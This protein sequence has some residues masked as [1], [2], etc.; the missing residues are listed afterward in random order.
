VTKR[1]EGQIVNNLN[2][3]YKNNNI[4]IQKLNNERERSF[5]C[6]NISCNNSVSNKN[7]KYNKMNRKN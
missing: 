7:F 2:V 6:N 1:N 4:K 5:D 3:N